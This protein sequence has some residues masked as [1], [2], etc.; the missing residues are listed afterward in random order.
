MPLN[1]A[2]YK[3]TW[4][5]RNPEKY[6]KSKSLNYARGATNTKNARTEWTGS[7][8]KRI[9]D[10]LRPKDRD[11]AEEMGRTVQAIQIR[12]CRIKNTT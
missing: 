1:R 6:N 7:E 3:K 10:P 9:L 2:V 8:D 5:Q 12:R 4:R 11:L